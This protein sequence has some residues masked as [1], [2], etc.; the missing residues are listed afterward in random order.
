MDW[1]EASGQYRYIDSRAAIG[2][3]QDLIASG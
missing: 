1:G 2:R 3:D